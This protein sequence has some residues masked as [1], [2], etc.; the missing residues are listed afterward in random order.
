MG[1]IGYCEEHALPLYFRHMR[2]A[3]VMLG[4]SNTHRETIAD[5][6]LGGLSSSDTKSKKDLPVRSVKEWGNE[7]I[8]F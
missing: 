1:G 3:E 8:A 7:R 4:D 2:M 5:A 6:L